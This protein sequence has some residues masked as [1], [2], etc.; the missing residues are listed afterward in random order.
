VVCL[1]EVDCR[2]LLAKR[3]A[4]LSHELTTTPEGAAEAAEAIVDL[5]IRK[6][7]GV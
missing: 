2:L 4:L 7:P 6:R 3:G 5:S 1:Y